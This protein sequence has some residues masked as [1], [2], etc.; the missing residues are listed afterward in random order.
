MHNNYYFLRQL[1]RQLGQEIR[2][3]CIGEVF[4]QS[5]DELIISAYK[6]GKEFYIKAYLS[7]GFCCLSFPKTFSRA[8]KNSVNLFSGI[9]GCEI[10]DVVQ[11]DNDRSFYFQFTDDIQLL[12]KMHGNLSN[13]VLIKDNS[14]VEI[15]RKNLIKDNNI[16]PSE[17][18]KEL[19]V[20]REIFRLQK[21]N[22]KNI[23]PTLGNS[24]DRYLQN[25]NY[26]QLGI[27][28]KYSC[29]TELLN[30]LENPDYYLHS[31][32]DT[33]ARLSLYKIGK[34]DYEYG[35]PVE[36]VT[37]FFLKHISA[38]R[39]QKEKSILKNSIHKQ[40]KKLDAYIQKSLLHQR[41]L[42]GISNYRHIGDLIMSQLHTIKPYISEVELIDFITQTP[43]R[44]SL[45]P[46]LSPQANAEKYYKK[47][48]NQ[49]IE[50]DTLKTNIE[51]KKK[52]KENLL[53]ELNEIENIS[54]IRDI[55]KK[56]AGKP[57][58]TPPPFR[59]INFMDYEILVGKN[60]TKNDQ[61]TFKFA[62]KEDLF[63]HAKNSSGS[64]VLVRKK[65]N[66]N[67][68]KPVI[69]KAASL[70]AYYSKSKNENL[71]NVLYT[72]KKYVRKQKGAP[73]GTVI[74][75]REKVILVKPSKI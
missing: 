30:Y 21:G 55:T 5:K 39:L 7:P 74:V 66:Q 29:I 8:K 70:A 59:V 26:D 41:K 11:I 9:V 54:S 62:K 49:Q 24:F 56:A 43:V 38:S 71:C 4:S 69:E 22:V 73:P 67:F 6:N 53:A 60:A 68:P 2:G 47:A 75:E 61:L 20:T 23:V 15:F 32:D 57:D 45:K 72:P 42:L 16:R 40:I 44:I 36:A 31:D 33:I 12:F 13:I 51:L 10:K 18:S 58:K 46:N 34:N 64:H 50:I 65:S 27:N 63:L 48:K 17:L 28:E 14:A 37:D 3:F 19:P 35:T 25:K 52:Q 1:S